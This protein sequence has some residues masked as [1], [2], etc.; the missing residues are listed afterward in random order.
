MMA[1]AAIFLVWALLRP[2]IALP[3]GRQLVMLIVFGVVGIAVLQ[4]MLTS[5]IARLDVGL[6]LTIGYT[7]SLLS[8][9]WCL[10]VRARAPAAVVWLLMG[11]RWPAWRS[12]SGRRR[13]RCG[14]VPVDGLLFAGGWR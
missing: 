13:R 4:W 2:G 10:F 9:L 12:R 6:V 14:D 5:A 11:W 8:A 3:R 1:V 7:A